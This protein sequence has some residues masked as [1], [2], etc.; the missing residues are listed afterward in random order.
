MVLGRVCR[1]EE[2]LAETTDEFGIRL[3]L[4]QVAGTGAREGKEKWPR[5]RHDLHDNDLLP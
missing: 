2:S 5:E 1:G 3:P 4:A